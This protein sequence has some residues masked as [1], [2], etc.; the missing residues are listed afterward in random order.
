MLKFNLTSYHHESH[1]YC[2]LCFC[3]NIHYSSNSIREAGQHCSGYS[4]Y[5]FNY[6]PPCPPTNSQKGTSGEWFPL[7]HK[8]ES[9][10]VEEDSSSEAAG[11]AQQHGNWTVSDLVDR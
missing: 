5:Q 10:H 9:T 3:Q 1:F 4:F 11:F 7:C 2:Q 6:S 8:E